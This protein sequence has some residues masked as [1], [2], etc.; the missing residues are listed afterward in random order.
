MRSCCAR[1]IWGEADKIFTLFTRLYGKIDAVGKGVRRTK[2]SL[3]GRLELLTESSMTFHRGRSLDI[4]TSA[5]TVRSHWQGL[6]EPRTLA[7]ASLVAEIVDMFCEPELPL[8]EIY[9]LLANASLAIAG[10]VAPAGLVPRFEL[11]L[12]HALGLAPP[13][14]ACIRCGGPF[15][16]H[17]AWMDID[18]GGLGCE[19]CYG[20]R[21]DA[22][23]LDAADVENFR[24]LGAPRTAGAGATISATPKVARAV[25]D[26][27]TYHL[28]RRPKAPRL[29]RRVRDLMP[30]DGAVLALDVGSKRIGVAVSDPSGDWAFPHS[31]IERTNVRADVDA[32]VAIAKERAAKTIVVGDPLTMDGKRGIAAENIDA[33]VAHLA[34]AF[35]GAIARIDERLTTAAVQKSLIGADVSRAKRKTVVDKLAAQMILETYLARARA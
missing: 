6:T 20:A 21:G 8:D 28:G 7:A 19:T 23:A 27:V 4:I 22:H 29:A 35:D 34:R 13:D 2:S 18:A 14:D 32:I 3:G 31:T 9:A 26:L 15:N 11:R 10:S 12:L 25:D 16:A 33:F 1:A 24:A 17:G 30:I 5:V